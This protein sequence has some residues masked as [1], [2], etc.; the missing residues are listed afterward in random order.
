MLA[1][2][3]FVNTPEGLYLFQGPPGTGKTTT[4]VSML[5]SLVATDQRILVCAPSNKAVQILAERTLALMPDQ[6]IIL[7]GVEAKILP[8]LQEIAF[9]NWVNRYRNKLF[10]VLAEFELDPLTFAK[11][12]TTRPAELIKWSKT[13]EN[14]I[15]EA[16]R[17]LNICL[18]YAPEDFDKTAFMAETNQAFADY[19]GILKPIVLEAQQAAFPSLKKAMAKKSGAAASGID[20]DAIFAILVEQH[21]ILARNIKTVYDLFRQPEVILASA[22]VVF[23]TLSTAGRPSLKNFCARHRPFDALI[24]DEAGQSVE[25]ETLI[26]FDIAINARKALLVGDTR[27]LPA[28]TICPQ[29]K[30][31]HFEWSMMWR[32]LEENKQ[33]FHGLTVQY[34]MRHA[35]QHF[36]SGRYY[37]GRLLGHE[38]IV[39]R[40]CYAQRFVPREGYHLWVDS[41]GR[42]ERSQKSYCNREEA[43]SIVRMVSAIREHDITS[44]IGIISFYNGQVQLLKKMFGH[45]EK[46][47]PKMGKNIM[48]SSVDGFQGDEKDII[49]L[50]FVRSNPVGEVGFLWD[51][52]RLNVAI[53]RA[54]D[55]LIL[56]GSMQTFR[57]ALGSE[58]KELLDFCH[59]T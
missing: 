10:T 55:A 33:P 29:S 19:V 6:P 48:I 11:K 27:Q 49:I 50:S 43:A 17:L 53:T 45:E 31:T 36:P 8:H 7:V 4:I 16:N 46:S 3:G 32:L 47:N 58:L 20:S 13:L 14:K 51:F 21:R 25:A 15:E 41:R 9:D 30:E 23:C 40:P 22:K 52:R 24:V 34:R 18:R 59:Q 44:H 28:T 35:I 37:E 56:C 2:Q 54:K 42:E 12:I 57:S 26:P 5:E 1:V 38:S 39:N